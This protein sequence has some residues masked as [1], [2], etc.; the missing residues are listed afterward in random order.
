MDTARELEEFVSKPE[1]T[2]GYASFSDF[3]RAVLE[4][5]EISASEVIQNANIYRTYGYQILDG[6][7]KPGRDKVVA[8][9]L[10]LSLTLEE[11]QRALTVAGESVLYP[12]RHRDS[13]LIFGIH[14]HLTVPEMN[15]LLFEL[16]ENPLD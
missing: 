8:L 7:R 14:Q 5:R 11:T 6:K 4:E 2:A 15:E 10:A 16:K 13:I 3:F 1:Q 12:R 9:C